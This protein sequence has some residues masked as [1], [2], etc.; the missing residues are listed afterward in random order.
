MGNE[1]DDRQVQVSGD[2]AEH[3]A[4]FI[5]TG[6]GN[7]H[8][9]H[10]LHQLRPQHLLPRGGRTGFRGFVGGGFIVYIT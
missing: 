10:L 2:G 8:L 1:A 3:I 7:A 5:H 6:I 4:V 9:L